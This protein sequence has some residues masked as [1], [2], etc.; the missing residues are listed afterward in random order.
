MIRRRASAIGLS[1]F[2]VL[3][4]CSVM[5][6]SAIA[7]KAINTTAFTC[8]SSGGETNK[9]F[10]DAHCDEKVP[11]GT[12]SFEHKK[13]P[14][15]EK[16]EVE[17]TNEKVTEATKKSEPAI[18]K[19]K[20]GL[21][22]TEIQCAV[23]KGTGTF[24]NEETE[25]KHGGSGTGVS[26][27]S[28]CTVVQPLKCTVKEPVVAS[29]SGGPV[30]GLGAGANE[31]GAEVKGTGEKETFTVVTYEGAECSL[32][33]KTFEIR[34]S[35]IATSG[36][37]T[38]SPQTGKSTGATAVYTP[39]NEMEKLKLG[40]EAAEFSVIGTATVKGIPLSGTTVT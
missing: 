7:V 40:I 28:S 2:G 4:L 38:E 8:V 23:A 9:D 19:S 35:A 10:K 29:G 34:G 15:G 27:M 24:T 25:K 13:I 39:Q 37:T 12:G 1:L 21:T 11:A 33:G 20:V 26:E 31:M 5:A 6:P 14:A 18:L 32:K 16:T 36:P 30:E 17:F 22:K 3:F